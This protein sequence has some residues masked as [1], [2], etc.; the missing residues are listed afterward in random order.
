MSVTSTDANCGLSNGQICISPIG[1]TAPFTYQWNDPNNQTSACALNLFSNCYTGEILDANGCT[2]DSLICINDI[3]GPTVSTINS[4]DV[5]CFGYQDGVI[6][7]SVTG[8]SGNSAITWFDNLGNI[9]TNGN[10]QTILSTLSGGCYSIQATDN[11]GC[12]S[13]ISECINEPLALTASIFNSN[14][15]SCFQLCDGNAMVSVSGGTINTNYT[16]SWDDSNAQTTA[17]ATSLCSGNYTVTI[18]DDN[19]CSTQ[20][21]VIINEPSQ[22]NLSL[23]SLNNVLCYNQCNGSVEAVSYT[24]LPLPTILLV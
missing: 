20:S 22:V 24:H 6:E 15:V 13:S 1:G 5:T 4:S 7:I 14:D 17:T 21:S 18:S 9:I 19:N 3:S 10:G 23:V 12:I 16:Y 8:G 11:V 2:I